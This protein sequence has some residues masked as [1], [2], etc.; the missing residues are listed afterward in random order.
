MVDCIT[1][2]CSI[3]IENLQLRL[4]LS[5]LMF[6]LRDLKEN[7]KSKNYLLP[8]ILPTLAAAHA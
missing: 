6:M 8:W 7:T 3:A 2:F 5:T 1:L 4:P